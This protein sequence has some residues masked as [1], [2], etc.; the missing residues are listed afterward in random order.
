[1][2]DKAKTKDKSSKKPSRMPE[3]V[4]KEINDYIRGLEY[5]ERKVLAV[6]G[7]GDTSLVDT[8]KSPEASSVESDS[9]KLIICTTRKQS[10]AK[11]CE[12]V[13]ILQPGRGAIFPGSLVRANAELVNGKPQRISALEGKAA[14]ATL[15]IDLPG[16]VDEGKIR[17]D[18]PTD[19]EVRRA[20]SK[21]T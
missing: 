15:S 13:A 5:D 17:V 9:Q 7:E 6:N 16:L 1:P 12:E 2:K 8:P 21:V 11:N 3:K 14:K 20:I 18:N 4:K 19:A 10:L